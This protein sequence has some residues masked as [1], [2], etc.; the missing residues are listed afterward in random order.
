[1]FLT[2]VRSQ[3]GFILVVKVSGRRSLARL[4]NVL[5]SNGKGEECETCQFL[6]LL[7]WLFSLV[8]LPFLTLSKKEILPLN[9]LSSR[10]HVG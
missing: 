1:M 10:R 9:C 6:F 7:F 2:L 4:K 5:R 8:V 3:Y